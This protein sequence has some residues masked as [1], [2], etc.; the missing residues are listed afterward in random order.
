MPFPTYGDATATES[1]YSLADISA[2]S[3]SNRIH[4]TMYFTDGIS[5]Y[6]GQSPSSSSMLPGHPDVSLLRVYRE[7]SEQ[8]LTWYGSLPIAIKPDLYGTYRATGQAYVLR[9]RYWSARHNIY[10]PFVIYVTSRA[11]DEEVSVPVSAIKRCELCLAATRM[12][13]LTAGHVLSERTPYTFS[14]TQC[15]VSY[16]LILALAAQTPI[17]ADAV[18]DCLKL[19]ETAI[20]LLKPWAVAGSASSAAWK[21]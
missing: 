15:V 14:T 10:R 20:G 13:I 18:G 19:L 5:L 3:L 21:S 11:A 6:N 17:L 7:L 9:L 1:L 4:H 16:A 12:F 2:R 8:T